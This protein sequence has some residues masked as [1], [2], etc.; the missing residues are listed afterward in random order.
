MK[1]TQISD[2][3]INALSKEAEKLQDH[4]RKACKCWLWMMIGLVMMIF[5]CK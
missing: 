4:S 2:A 5:M 1:S 3:N